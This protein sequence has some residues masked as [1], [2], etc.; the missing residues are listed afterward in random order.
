MEPKRLSRE[1]FLEV[2]DRTPLVS[3]D[4]VIKDPEGKI[5]LGRRINE[6]AK[7]MWFVPGGRIMKNETLEEAFERVAADETGVRYKMNSASLI[8]AYTHFYNTNVYLEDGITTQYIALAYELTVPVRWNPDAKEQHTEYEWVGKDE[9]LGT[10]V[11]PTSHSISKID[12]HRNT[13]VYFG[14]Y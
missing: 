13:L 1:E 12:V 3:I 8:G 10:N 2:L 11:I 6:P 5:L 9:L 7:G 14:I 4:L